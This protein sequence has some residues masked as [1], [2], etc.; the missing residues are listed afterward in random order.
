M[1]E[2]LSCEVALHLSLDPMTPRDFL[3]TTVWKELTQ[4]PRF[5]AW[6]AAHD[7]LAKDMAAGR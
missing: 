1:K 3:K 4:Q 5:R 7:R 6:N 2:L